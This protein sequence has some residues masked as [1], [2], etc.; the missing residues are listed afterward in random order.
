MELILTVICLMW[1]F[2]Y[3]AKKIQEEKE[4]QKDHKRS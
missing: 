1:I 4:K 2:N 3:E